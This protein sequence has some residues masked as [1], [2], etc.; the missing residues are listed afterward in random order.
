MGQYDQHT[1]AHVAIA[2]GQEVFRKGMVALLERCDEID[3]VSES[4]T[5][6]DLEHSMS[7]CS[8]DVAVMDMGLIDANAESRCVSSG[9][10]SKTRVLVMCPPD[11]SL[12]I[13]G[14]FKQGVHGIISRG[15]RGSELVN[16]ISCLKE[17]EDYLH[18]SLGVQMA[19]HRSST[20]VLTARECQI[21]KLIALG[22]TNREISQAIYVSVRTVETH[23]SHI[24]AKL[25]LERRADLV[26]WALK[27]C[28][29][30]SNSNGIGIVDDCGIAAA[31][32]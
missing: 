26:R 25:Q 28:I 13:V 4:A 3:V 18:P 15:A 23:R 2:D 19:Q 24:M 17:G 32:G 7:M 29:I 12:D 21:A 20:T 22:Y 27:N 6:R 1:V 10:S 8:P 11:V 30:G 16:A 31:L 14:L 5:L 9:H